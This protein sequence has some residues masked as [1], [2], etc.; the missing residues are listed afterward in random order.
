MMMMGKEGEMPRGKRRFPL[1][2]GPESFFPAS[3]L[4]FLVKVLSEICPWFNKIC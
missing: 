3:P 2:N 1:H 4:K